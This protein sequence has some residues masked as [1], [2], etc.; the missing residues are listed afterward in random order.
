MLRR[1]HLL[2]LT[3]LM[4]PKR[5]HLQPW[6]EQYLGSK[7]TYLWC[8]KRKTRMNTH[9]LCAQ[10]TFLAPHPSTNIGKLQLTGCVRQPLFTKHQYQPASPDCWGDV[11]CTLDFHLQKSYSLLC[12][13]SFR[14][15]NCFSWEL[16]SNEALK[17]SGCTRYRVGQ[18]L[19]PLLD[20]SLK[21][22]IQHK[23]NL[24]ASRCDCCCNVITIK[25]TWIQIYDGS[26]Y[27]SSPSST[28]KSSIAGA[29]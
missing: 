16:S 17:Q 1:T 21:V 24:H 3:H 28:L 14:S 8:K 9:S 15:C 25:V 10:G 27:T 7:A 22:L 12:C 26:D 19:P 5:T 29:G 2:A 20:S 23:A 4:Q 11:L 6:F 18:Q 13:G